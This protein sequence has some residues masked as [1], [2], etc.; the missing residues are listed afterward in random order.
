[1]T[2]RAKN[3]HD[4]LTLKKVRSIY[5]P[6]RDEPSTVNCRIGGGRKTFENGSGA[7]QNVLTKRYINNNDVGTKEGQGSPRVLECVSSI[8]AANKSSEPELITA[9]VFRF[10]PNVGEGKFSEAQ[11]K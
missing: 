5:Q 6:Y 2:T 7:D 8:T 9:L 3:H 4:G 10:S 1:M 11:L